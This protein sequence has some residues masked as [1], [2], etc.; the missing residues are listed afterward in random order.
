MVEWAGSFYS[1]ERGKQTPNWRDRNSGLIVK[2]KPRIIQ[3]E[4]RN[5]S[6][7]IQGNKVLAIEP[8]G[9]HFFNS[10]LTKKSGARVIF[11]RRVRG[12]AERKAMF[13]KIKGR[14]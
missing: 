13:S 1:R 14:R 2:N 6:I 5:K 9:K 10:D 11:A 4:N 12:D 8:T 3:G 7:I